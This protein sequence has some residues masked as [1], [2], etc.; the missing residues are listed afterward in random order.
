MSSASSNPS[1]SGSA[2]WQPSASLATLRL[3]ARLLE[4]TRRF[5]AARGV[6]EVDVPTLAHHTVTAPNI[7]SAQVQLP[8]WPA[9]LYLQTSPEYLMKRLLA[10]GSGDIYQIAHVFRGSEQSRQHNAEFTLIEWYRCGL[11][12]QQLIDEVELLAVTLLELPPQAPSERLRY[13]QAFERELGC[14]P[15]IAT[16][17]QLRRLAL[18]HG[19]EARLTERCARDELLDWLMGITVG[20]R[21]GAQGLC[22]VHHYPASQAALARLD[23]ADP[24]CAL[25][26]ELYYRGVELANGFEELADPAEQR[27][28]FELDQAERRRAGAPVPAID[29]ALIAA[30]VSGLPPVSGVALGFDRLLMLRI[31]ASDLSAVLPF[32]LERA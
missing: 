25:R 7:H 31:G 1:P 19:L 4:S 12:M 10:A 32:T 20:P 3:R 28:R 14:D 8:G 26:F 18:A 9:T 2:V 27:R 30:L 16:D 23:A 13:A 24:R 29:E 15:L 5:F 6:L 21:L 22:F 11:S 17:A